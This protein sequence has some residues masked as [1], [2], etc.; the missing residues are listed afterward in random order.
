MSIDNIPNI[1]FLETDVEVIKKNIIANFERAVGRVLYPSD[2]L[3]IIIQTFAMILSQQASYLDFI[4]KQNFVKY[5]EDDYIENIGALVGVERLQPTN[6]L[7]T[8]KFTIST[9]HSSVIVV[10]KG[11][12][13]ATGNK[14]YFETTEVAQIA[15]GDVNVV[16]S[17]ICLEAGSKGNGFDI[18]QINQIVDIFPYFESVENITV[19]NGGS[20]IESLESYRQRIFYAPDSFS[21]AGPSGAYKFYAKSANSLISD[22]SVSSPSAG[23]VELIPL[24]E[25]GGIPSQDILD[26]VYNYCN[27][28]KIRPL[29]DKVA[30]NAPDVRNYN[31]N[32]NY[33]ISRSNGNSSNKIGEKVQ[34]VINE[35]ILWQ[36]E[37]LGRDINPSKLIELIM[38]TGIKRVE[39]I[40]PIFTKL[41]YNEVA[42]LGN[43]NVVFGGL[44]NE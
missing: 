36:K 32:I 40:E 43:V 20:D 3:L 5:A 6:A 37:K 24:L 30:V 29:T 13:V 23:V 33:F 18:G 44:E 17:G 16:V 26:E 15:I 42:L 41:E 2:P 27:D 25:K 39:I 38:K 1:D 35:Y 31:I 9:P 14:I 10:P 12:R 21:V 22:V 8:F 4:A 19:S 34:E 7:V 28:D 11:T